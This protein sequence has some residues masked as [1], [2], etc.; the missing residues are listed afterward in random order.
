[1][2]CP[3]MYGRK[4]LIFDHRLDTAILIMFEKLVRALTLHS[5]VYCTEIDIMFENLVRAK[6][7]VNLKLL[8]RKVHV[9]QLLLVPVAQQNQD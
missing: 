9:F 8:E 1:M 3:S 2:P 4:G 7:L 5:C 6:K